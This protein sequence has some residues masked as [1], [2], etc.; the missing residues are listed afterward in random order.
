MSLL[1]VNARTTNRTTLYS[2]FN[3]AF[4]NYY[5]DNYNYA[6]SAATG[7]DFNSFLVFY[8]L[9]PGDAVIDWGDGIVETY[10]FVQSDNGYY[11]LSFRSLAV[12]YR[13]DPNNPDWGLGRDGGGI[14]IKPY[15][16]H[17]YADDAA[18]NRVIYLTFTNQV[19]RFASEALK[20][21][22]FPLLETPELQTLILTYTVNVMEIPVNRLAKLRVLNTLNLT[23]LGA[24]LQYLPDSLF[25]MP[26]LEFLTLDGVADLSNND[27]SNIRRVKN[28]R[29]LRNLSLR[30][31]LLTNY[32]K[33]FNDLPALRMLRVGDGGAN[34][35][36][37]QFPEV[38]T[39]NPM[40]MRF[41]Y[42]T[43]E[44]SVA[45]GRT[46]WGDLENRGVGNLNILNAERANDLP[47][48]LPNYIY[49]MRSMATFAFTSSARTQQRTDDFI[50]NLYSF[51][52]DWPQIT[53]NAV[54]SDG[55]RNQ[56]YGLSVVLY[57][58]AFPQWAFAPSGT[59]QAPAGFV[60]GSANGTP[61][62]PMEKIYVLEKNY[63]HIWI[64]KP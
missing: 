63:G 17:H 32:I 48:A 30:G 52:T 1:R 54:A 45:G 56:F 3:Y 44:G 8:S 33:E 16:N 47:L 21:N 23:A 42:I 51:I 49:Q 25:D 7:P 24:V 12:D 22:G 9:E 46:N 28:A 2:R 35:L 13:K 40:I 62:T 57:E 55:G 59:H 60:E 15:P 31:C 6:P 50:S 61:A 58:A 18:T 43:G 10:N 38:A 4:H 26:S 34:Q 20:M 53:M 29:G 37:P 41:E 39:I 36:T 64:I 27:A 11:V 19:H 5:S 14:P